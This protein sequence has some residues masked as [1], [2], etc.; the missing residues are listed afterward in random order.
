MNVGEKLSK[1]EKFV[2][3]DHVNRYADVSGDRNPIHV[4]TEFAATSRFGRK[5]AHGMMVAS[6]ISE[7][8]AQTFGQ[9]WHQSGSGRR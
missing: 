3:E 4:D 9:R 8:M 2:T 6:T 5:I 1:V 7:M